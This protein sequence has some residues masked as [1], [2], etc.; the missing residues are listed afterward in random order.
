MALNPPQ[1]LSTESFFIAVVD[2]A[3][4]LMR[5]QDACTDTAEHPLVLSCTDLPAAQ[6]ASQQLSEKTSEGM[7]VV[8]IVEVVATSG[9]ATSRHVSVPHNSRSVSSLA[10]DLKL[11]AIARGI[12]V[13]VP[14]VADPDAFR[15]CVVEEP[16]AQGHS[17]RTTIPGWTTVPRG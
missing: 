6:R 15:E 13:V 11:L 8:P 2:R 7:T 1:S 3:C 10:I 14:D 9:R 16:T 5:D 17:T 12:I 4:D